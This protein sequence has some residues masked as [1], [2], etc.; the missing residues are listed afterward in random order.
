[1]T[2][3]FLKMNKSYCT[4]VTAAQVTEDADSYIFSFLN[5][6]SNDRYVMKVD[7]KLY[8]MAFEGRE[9]QEATEPFKIE[10]KKPPAMS[11]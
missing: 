2:S 7:K 1:M 10:P 8:D 5:F 11:T 4:F 9:K 6:F 3:N